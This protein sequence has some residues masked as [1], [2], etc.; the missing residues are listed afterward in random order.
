MVL[1]WLWKAGAHYKTN[2]NARVEEEHSVWRSDVARLK[3]LVLL[4][5]VG[6]AIPGLS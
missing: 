4:E 5:G 3:S 1:L 6:V 2:L